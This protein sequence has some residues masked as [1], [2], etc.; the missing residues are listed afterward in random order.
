[1]SNPILRITD[2]TTTVNLLSRRTGFFLR[3]YTPNVGEYKG[4]GVYQ[5]SP[6]SDYRRLVFRR[7]DN[8][9]ESI[10][11]AVRSLSQD[12]FARQ[13]RILRS[14]LQ[15]AGAYWME[16]LVDD[17]TDAPL[18]WIEAKTATETEMR[19]A[20]LYDGR[21][22][23]DP[24][25]YRQ[26]FLQI[27]GA[28]VAESL[29]ITYERS[30]WM[31]HPP[32][33]SKAIEIANYGYIGL[34]GSDCYALYFSS[35]LSST[36]YVN[37]GSHS[38]FD[39]MPQGASG[40]T[41]EGWIRPTQ[42][43]GYVLTKGWIVQMESQSGGISFTVPR[44][45][46]DDYA[47]VPAENLT[48]SYDW[49][50]YAFTYEA[51]SQEI[52]CWI[53]GI[54]VTTLDTRSAT[55][56]GS[57]TT[58][59]SISLLMGNSST[60]G[61]DEFFGLIGWQRL[62][63]VRRYT[64]STI[65][66][67]ELGNPPD[68]DVNTIAQWNMREASGSTLD[69]AEGTSSLDGTIAGA[70]WA[71]DGVWQ[72]HGT[73]I[74]DVDDDGNVDYHTDEVFMINAPNSFNLTRLYLNAAGTNQMWG[75]FPL[76]IANA[77]ATD[78][79]YF[80]SRPY[81]PHSYNGITTAIIFDVQQPNVGGTVVWEFWNGS[82]WA[83]MSGGGL[84]TSSALQDT[85]EGF[86]VPG[87]GV[88][89]FDSIPNWERNS[90][91]SIGV[92]AFWLRARFSVASSQDV[93]LGSKPYSPI[94]NWVE[95][96]PDSF[97]GDLPTK[98]LGTLEF[99]TTPANRG[100]NHT[101]D[102]YDN[103]YTNRVLVGARSVSRGKQF[104]SFL[105]FPYNYNTMNSLYNPI[106]PDYDVE[107]GWYPPGVHP[108]TGVIMLD[109]DGL[110]GTTTTH[111][112]NHPNS[113]GGGAFVTADDYDY[114]PSFAVSFDERGALLY[115]GK[116]RILVPFVFY[117]DIGG[118]FTSFTDIGMGLVIKEY[119]GV[120][121]DGSFL[122]SSGQS[123]VERE[124]YVPS[125]PVYS[126]VNEQSTGIR[127]AD[128]GEVTLGPN[129]KT[130]IV[131]LNFGDYTYGSG[132][133]AT[134]VFYGMYF[135]PTDE[136]FADI[137]LHDAGSLPGIDVD[138]PKTNSSYDQLQFGSL[139][140]TDVARLSAETSTSVYNGTVRANKPIALPS[141]ETYRLHFLGV[142]QLALS[143]SYYS[144]WEH[145]AFPS[146]VYSLKLRGVDRYYAMRGNSS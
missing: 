40:F 94:Q 60:G 138:N 92:T 36:P 51:T 11:V 122:A 38:N 91:G 116:F 2:G 88:V 22:V 83:T 130:L 93:I 5:N 25:Y 33:E 53:N 48:F 9:S 146:N 67:P 35:L 44:S 46:I 75:S 52:R 89:V 111:V 61:G 145:I 143:S 42:G 16:R 20:I 74:G 26:P 15:Q 39:N 77:S 86:T 14:L 73:A 66:V 65:P 107:E 114:M 54:E 63:N 124:L 115:Q 95:I 56:T 134:V 7:R 72:E 120:N 64:S 103:P 113:P 29:T 85:T 59:A 127:L 137:V 37:F 140:H 106:T 10:T 96:N 28:A 69:N 23:D 24:N 71:F 43:E 142:E 100:R 13:T 50:H 21:I 12:E 4:G 78:A 30:D 110:D 82:T 41:V 136:M 87:T 112:T 135:I 109:E 80:S 34:P 8:I 98:L 17:N 81:A 126:P 117:I 6:V 68:I 129:P 141:N 125:H 128:F 3:D 27:E 99:Y 139:F 97:N 121:E 47:L 131:Q 45:G 32:N 133:D 123:D 118:D 108:S 101:A 90:P 31:S 105:P 55:G 57:I 62:S 132:I 70:Q 104:R 58:D 119:A 102:F 144:S 76:T 19:Y 1:M 49:I 18:V 84:Y 79:V